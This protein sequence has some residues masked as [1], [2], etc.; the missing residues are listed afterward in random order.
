M[1]KFLLLIIVV[2]LAGF[3]FYQFVLKK[4]PENQVAKTAPLA[5][6]SHSTV[7]NTAFEKIMADY[8]MVGNAL[9]EWDSTAADKAALQVQQSTIALPLG[10]LKADSTAVETA[11]NFVQSMDAEINGFLGEKSIEQKRRA[12]NMLTSELYDLIRTVRYDG[13]IIYH[14]KCQMAFG[15]SSE[16]YWLTNQRVITNPYLGKLH[17]TYKNKMV[18]CGETVDSLNFLKN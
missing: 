13:E 5:I 11:R 15:D 2:I 16:G 9:V 10:E 4:G 7:F 14:D 12:F 3:T 8:Y 17:P 6:N 18:G 1:K